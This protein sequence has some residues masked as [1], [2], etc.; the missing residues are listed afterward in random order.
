M[1]AERY[2]FE[3][4]EQNA[5]QLEALLKRFGIKVRVGSDLEASALS[6]VEILE[7]RRSE[8]VADWTKDL[9]T[10]VANVVG[11]SEFGAQLLAARSHSDFGQL[12]PHLELLNEGQ[13]VQTRNASVLD[14]PTNKIFE[15]I[16]AC[17]AM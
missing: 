12:I 11:L 15:L 17:W 16:V 3:A 4:A 13:V 8:A 9:R 7:R 2:T 5:I 14:Q 10:N 6:V 1:R